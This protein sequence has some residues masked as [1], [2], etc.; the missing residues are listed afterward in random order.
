MARVQP[1]PVHQVMSRG[2]RP[3][4]AIAQS[5]R[6]SRGADLVLLCSCASGPILTHISPVYVVWCSRDRTN[7]YQGSAMYLGTGA[8]AWFDVQ[9]L[10]AP[11]TPLSQES[12]HFD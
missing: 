10:R 7:G 5:A 8:N 11:C 3:L 4:G 12:T 2:N 6:R 1:A 9:R